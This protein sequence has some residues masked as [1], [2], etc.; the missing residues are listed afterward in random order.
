MGGDG[1]A[2]KEEADDGQAAAEHDNQPSKQGGPEIGLVLKVPMSVFP[3]AAKS[4]QWSR[5]QTYAPCVSSALQWLVLSSDEPGP[6]ILVM[7]DVARVAEVREALALALVHP[8]VAT[9][10][11]GG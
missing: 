5:E 8:D 1:V 3:I 10:E 7:V 9:D 2:R 11:V 4:G 6:A